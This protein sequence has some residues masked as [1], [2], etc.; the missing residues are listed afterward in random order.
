MAMRYDSRGS[1]TSSEIVE[2]WKDVDGRKNQK[3]SPSHTIESNTGVTETN[4]N[5]FKFESSPCSIS[6]S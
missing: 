4:T 1:Q 2:R 6:A 3:E 5:S